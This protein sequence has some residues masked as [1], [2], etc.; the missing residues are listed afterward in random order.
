M[1]VTVSARNDNLAASTKTTNLL[2]ATD[3]NQMPFD[4]VVTVWG[5]ISAL[6][7]NLEMGVGSEKAITDREIP[8]IG[9]SIDVSAHEIT[10]FPAAGGSNLSLFLRETAASATTDALWIVRADE[11]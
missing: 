2:A 4:G 1:P 11:A 9:T 10:S 3:L 6:G 8:F 7:V 5:V